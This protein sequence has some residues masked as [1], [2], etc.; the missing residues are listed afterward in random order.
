MSQ[1]IVI[2]K[3][4]MFTAKELIDAQEAALNAL[5]QAILARKIEFP[6]EIRQLF[7]EH[8]NFLTNAKKQQTT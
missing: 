5:Y 7:H 2:T 8:M 6:V 3:A 4:K 1:G